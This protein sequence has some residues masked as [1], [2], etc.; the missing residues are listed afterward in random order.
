MLKLKHCVFLLVQ[1]IIEMCYCYY[2]ISYPWYRFKK[3]FE[4]ICVKQESLQT[5]FTFV[6]LRQLKLKLFQ[7]FK[8]TQTSKFRQSSKAFF[9]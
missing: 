1:S 8:N 2:I 7:K 5:I 6:F 4:W 9:R 3:S